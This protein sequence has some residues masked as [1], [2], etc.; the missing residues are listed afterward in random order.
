[1]KGWLHHVSTCMQKGSEPVPTPTYPAGPLAGFLIS[2]PR[3]GLY[4]PYPAPDNPLRMAAGPALR[5]GFSRRC[6]AER[7]FLFTEMNAAPSADWGTGACTARSRAFRNILLRSATSR[8][9][10]VDMAHACSW[11]TCLYRDGED[12]RKDEEDIRECKALA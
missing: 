6:Q 8:F 12:G 5:S 1:M 3:H 4:A 10:H 9:K 11:G 7:L 2:G